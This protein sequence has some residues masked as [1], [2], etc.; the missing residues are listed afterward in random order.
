MSDVTEALP[1]QGATSPLPRATSA[2]LR[3]RIEYGFFLAA[4]KIASLLPLETCADWSAWCRR[5]MGRFNSRRKRASA[6]LASAFPELTEPEREALVTQ[7]W[8]NLG[9]V[10]AETF[11]LGNFIK[12]PSR[13]EM[14]R[15]SELQDFI[16]GSRGFIIVSLHS[17]NWELAALGPLRAGLR[18]AG[19]YQTIKNPLVDAC[20]AK[21][22]EP[23][24][25]AALLRKSRETRG[26]S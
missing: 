5:R 7:V 23:L 15:E 14:T 1:P 22:R 26:A 21:L 13:Y 4:A 16:A 9:R 10:F 17:A 3:H 6:Q 8:D 2:S 20:M 19:I 25:P 11:H 12:D 24:Y 18:I